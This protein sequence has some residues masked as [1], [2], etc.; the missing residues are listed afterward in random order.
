MYYAMII[1][2][3]IIKWFVA[4]V[5]N[6]YV[7][8]CYSYMTKGNSFNNYLKLLL[9]CLLLNLFLFIEYFLFYNK[10]NKI[11]YCA[12]IFVKIWLYMDVFY[13]SIYLSCN[14][15]LFATPSLKI[16][17]S[18]WKVFYHVLVLNYIFLYFLGNFVNHEFFQI[19][20]LNLYKSSDVLLRRLF[21]CW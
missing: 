6:T 17:G 8:L 9:A 14:N 21:L 20:L 12:V 1:I 5:Y 13:I 16:V 11:I 7:R 18:F 3:T 10:R 2:I 15:Q 19:N 4:Y